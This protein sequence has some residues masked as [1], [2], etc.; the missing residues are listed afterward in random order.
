LE[1]LSSCSQSSHGGKPNAHFCRFLQYTYLFLVL[2]SEKQTL[3]GLLVLLCHDPATTQSD[4]V[5]L[6]NCGRAF[7]LNQLES[8]NAQSN[9]TN[10]IKQLVD[11]A[12]TELALLK[13]SA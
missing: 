10:T 13:P 8:E 11:N 12:G 9:E 6:A 7:T 4:I 2:D 3:D 5:R 1:H